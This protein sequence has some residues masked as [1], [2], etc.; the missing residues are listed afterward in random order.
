MGELLEQAER[1]H[2]ARD[3]RSEICRLEAQHQAERSTLRREV[4]ELR[5]ELAEALASHGHAAASPP[6][7]RARPELPERLEHPEPSSPCMTE[8]GVYEDSKQ[9]IE[10]VTHRLSTGGRTKAATAAYLQRLEVQFFEGR[11]KELAA[12][13]EAASRELR[14]EL[15]QV[16]ATWDASAREA[17]SELQA[18]RS[19]LADL[20]G[21][22]GH[23]RA[24]LSGDLLPGLE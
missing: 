1:G 5:S 17:D 6:V 14:Q 22:V 10:D 15:A 9:F 7:V 2:V 19:S 24:S 12:A 16:E 21:S 4:E 13:A 8:N 23:R 3:L 20:Q 11:V 18:L